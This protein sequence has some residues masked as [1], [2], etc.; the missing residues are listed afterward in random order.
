VSSVKIEVFLSTSNNANDV[1]LAR[2]LEEIKSEF[3][4]D[5]EISTHNEQNELFSAYGL[6]ATPAVVIDEMIKITGFCPSKETLVAAFKE[7]GLE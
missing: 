5:V 6:A 2:L 7:S 1:C 4:D 3:G